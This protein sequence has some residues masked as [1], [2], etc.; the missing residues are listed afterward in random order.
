MFVTDGWTIGIIIK[1]D[2]LGTPENDNLRVGGKGEIQCATQGRRPAIQRAKGTCGPV[3]CPKQATT[4]RDVRQ[5]VGSSCACRMRGGDQWCNSILHKF[6]IAHSPLRREI[7][8]QSQTGDDGR[9]AFFQKT[10]TVF[11]PVGK[12]RGIG[13]TVR[14]FASLR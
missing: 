5:C 12:Q 14:T 11:P 3:H 2:K 7:P 8:K 6:V 9:L 13:L 1:R 10:T 4:V